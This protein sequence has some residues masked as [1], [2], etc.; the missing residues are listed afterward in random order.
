MH[1]NKTGALK[2]K[3][4][5]CV[6]M[7]NTVSERIG[8]HLLNEFPGNLEL[9]A[10]DHI[11]A[12]II[13]KRPTKPIDLFT[14]HIF[15]NDTYRKAILAG[16]EEF[17]RSNRHENL[18]SSDEDRIQAMFQFKTCWTKMTSE[19]KEYIKKSMQQLIKISAQYVEN[20]CQLTDKTK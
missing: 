9:C 20:N 3:I 5:N 14:E 1:D 2:D 17:F 7:F 10:Y 4:N 19:S 16:D 6:K 15:N 11:V 12:K 18:T 13:E 8:K